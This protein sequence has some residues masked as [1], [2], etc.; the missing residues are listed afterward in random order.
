MATFVSIKAE[1]SKFYFKLTCVSKL[2]NALVHVRLAKWEDNWTAEVASCNLPAC[3]IT[4]TNTMSGK[5][6]IPVFP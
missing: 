5:I 3:K 2:L 1:T 6:Y 4:L